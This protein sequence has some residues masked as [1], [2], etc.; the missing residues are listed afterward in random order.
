MKILLIN[1]VIKKL[2]YLFS[3][4]PL[5]FYIFF[6]TNDIYANAGQ[7]RYGDTPKYH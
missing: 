6:F 3:A 1:E 4:S 5:I 7:Y 2:C